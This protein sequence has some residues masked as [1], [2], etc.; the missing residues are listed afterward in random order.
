[1]V[2][3]CLF[4]TV[5]LERQEIKHLLQEE[6]LQFG[7]MMLQLLIFRV[8]GYQMLNELHLLTNTQHGD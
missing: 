1:M 7:F 5:P 6:W 2:V 3:A 8:Q 4:I